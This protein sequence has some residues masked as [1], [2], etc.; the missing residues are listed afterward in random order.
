MK[1]HALKCPS[2]SYHSSAGNFAAM[3]FCPGCRSKLAVPLDMLENKKIVCPKCTAPIPL[4]STISL[5]SDEEEEFFEDE[6]ENENTFK[7]GDFF[8]KYE[9]IKLIGQGGMGEVY[10]AKH[11]LLHREAALKIM[12]ADM[13]AKNQVFAKRFI[14]EAKIANKIESPNIISVFDVGIDSKT[15]M[16]FIAME[17]VKGVNIS[18]MIKARGV[19]NERETLKIIL[20][21]LDALASMEEQKIVHRDIKPSNI[22]ID[23]K[24]EIKLADLGIAKFDNHADGEL[25]LTQD[26][27]VFGTPN[28]ASPEQ[29][30]SSHNVD[31]RSD[32]Y[33][34]G[35][36]MF[37][38]VAGFPPYVG[39]SAMDTMLKVLN[40]PPT[41]LESLKLDLSPGFIELVNSMLKKDPAQRPQTVADL[42]NRIEKIL[43]GD[44]EIH[45]QLKYFVKDTVKKLK[46]HTVTISELPSLFWTHFSRIIY[47]RMTFTAII[48]AVL[49]FII[50]A[51]F[52]NREYL[53][54]RVKSIA[55]DLKSAPEKKKEKVIYTLDMNKEN[56]SSNEINFNREKLYTSSDKKNSSVQS[57][58]SI[59]KTVPENSDNAVPPLTDSLAGRIIRYKKLSEELSEMKKNASPMPMLD[60]RIEFVRDCY[61][62]LMKQTANRRAAA[63]A[64]EKGG[65]DES[66]SVAFKRIYRRLSNNSDTASDDIAKLLDLI[67]K[68]GFNPNIRVED[69][70]NPENSMPL[71]NAVLFGQVIP[72]PHRDAFVAALIKLKVDTTTL[73]DEKFS[74]SAIVEYG[75]DQLGGRLITALQNKNIKLAE[76]LI[77]SGADVNSV[78]SD[79]NSVLHLAMC[80][81]KLS[82]I[83]LIISA[84]ANINAVN[85]T[86]SQTPLFYAEKYASD[87][88]VKLLIQA[89]A[90]VEYKD[91]YGKKAAD[92]RYISEFRAALKAKDIKKLTGIFDKYPD[93]VNAELFE[94]CTPL[95]YACSEMHLPLIKLLLGR[96][97][98]AGKTTVSNPVKPIQMMYKMPCV[99]YNRSEFRKSLEIFKELL[100]N[101]IDFYCGPYGT[102][103]R[104]LLHYSLQQLCK[105]D[106]TEEHFQFIYAMLDKVDIDKELPSLLEAIYKPFNVFEPSDTNKNKKK[107]DKLRYGLLKKLLYGGKDLSMPE[108]EHIFAFCGGNI[109]ITFEELEL[110]LKNRAN[111]N[112]TDHKG[113]NALFNLC[114]AVSENAEFFDASD[115]LDAACDRAEF[116]LYKNIK[117]DIVVDGISIGDMKLHH[118]FE[119]IQGIKNLRRKHGK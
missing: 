62:H 103:S 39:S 48:G 97:A 77:R 30:R 80:F 6:N 66:V 74:N 117:T 96:Y 85:K 70:K 45:Y 22:M 57:D 24:G 68:N 2:C 26:N 104:S 38:M 28:Y 84:G 36:T 111:I 16:L 75:I 88:I 17:Y 33:S 27:V 79:G 21:V 107:I 100:A 56:S 25:T 118:D 42:K 31:T 20:C 93:L 69:L 115:N 86:E 64:V 35:A 78:D 99:R 10:L 49:F 98:D 58:G 76:A 61:E 8:D 106:M 3:I 114:L 29:C 52:R 46:N 54:N 89:N 105:N 71:L 92:Y 34:L 13:A 81:N 11:L 47:R 14:R 12:H 67:K 90:D 9:I 40:E 94:G 32:I 60:L 51:G 110:L 59:E 53:R 83:K 95:Q 108:F 112:S 65:Y 1:E 113:R 109:N 72:D 102:E 119:A 19:F 43:K 41:S 73:A 82:L 18:E 116:L 7:P 50:F 63:A 91:I 15:E 37:H 87:D 4:M 44:C 23:V 5:D 55:A 101:N